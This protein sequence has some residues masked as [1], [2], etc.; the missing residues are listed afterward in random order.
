MYERYKWMNKNKN[1]KEKTKANIKN[2]AIERKAKIIKRLCIPFQSGWCAVL[3]CFSYCKYSSTVYYILKLPPNL[4]GVCSSDFLWNL[5]F[6]QPPSIYWSGSVWLPSRIFRS[7]K[8]NRNSTDPRIKWNENERVYRK[9]KRNNT[10]RKWKRRFAD[11]LHETTPIQQNSMCIK[12][13]T[14]D[15]WLCVSRNI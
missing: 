7:A 10:K 2:K 11:V 13:G 9:C 3:V 5:V 1:E 15:S 4:V 12:Y 14:N 8:R 6:I